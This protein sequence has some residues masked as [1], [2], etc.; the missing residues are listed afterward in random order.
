MSERLAAY[1]VVHDGQLVSS[2]RM[3]GFGVAAHGDLLCSSADGTRPERSLSPSLPTT[4]R[5]K[6][7][8]YIDPHE[9]TRCNGHGS[10][11]LS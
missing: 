2:T 5:F 8:A 11:A 1:L 7:P 4:D 6:L 3:N 10:L 9:L